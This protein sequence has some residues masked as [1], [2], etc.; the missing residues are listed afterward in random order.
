MLAKVALLKSI[1]PNLTTTEAATLAQGTHVASNVTK[2]KDI[3]QV[4]RTL[5]AYDGSDA[6]NP[7]DFIAL[8]EHQCAQLKIVD[9]DDMMAIVISKFKGRALRWY[10]NNQPKLNTYRKLVDGMREMF[11]LS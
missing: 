5:P 11:S 8:V 1:D 9:P 6:D 10:R 4:E 2:S 3:L 7:S